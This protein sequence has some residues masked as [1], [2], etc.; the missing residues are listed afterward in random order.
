MAL[1]KRVVGTWFTY[2]PDKQNTP[3]SEIIV[4]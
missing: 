4:P 1:Q 3:T 2:I